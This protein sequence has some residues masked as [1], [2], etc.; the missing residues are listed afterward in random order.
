MAQSLL[1]STPAWNQIVINGY[2]S[3]LRRNA[4][5]SEVQYWASQLQANQITEDGFLNQLLS[6]GE[7]SALT[8]NVAQL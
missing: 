4:S 1:N 2:A 5:D 6:S 7:F 8:R 3:V